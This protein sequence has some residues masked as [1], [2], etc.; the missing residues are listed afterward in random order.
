MRFA[1]T[2]G[3]YIAIIAC[4]LFGQETGPAPMTISQAVDRASRTF[5]SIQASTEQVNAAIAGIRIARTNYLPSMD[6]LGQVNRATRNNVFGLL[7]PQTVIPNISGPV[8]GTNNGATV[9]GSAAGILVSWEPFDFGR[10][11]AVVESAEATRSR[12][13]RT[14]KRTQFD[15]AT[16]TAAAFMTLLASQQ[17]MRVA[18]AAVDRAE[19]LVRSVNALVTAQLRPGADLSRADTELDAAE[20][21]LIQSQQSVEVARAAL[22]EYTGI[23][24]NRTEAAPGTLLQLPSDLITAP[25]DLARHPAAQEQNAVVQESQARLRI[26][27][28]TYR[29][30]FKL[31]VGASARG[32]GALTDGATLGGW[33]GLGPTFFNA[34]AGF[35]VGFPILALPSVRAQERQQN[36]PNRLGIGR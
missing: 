14:A 29:P 13:E 4:A 31:Q 34:A 18:Q 23:D 19:V 15:V 36:A 8:L 12:A 5:P 25:V 21:Q 33:N 35:T 16:I 32:T 28:R 2:L 26:L 20:T 3:I 27:E 30:T 24:L 22:A 10:R 9:W 17:T 7:L 11:H 6:A 1:K